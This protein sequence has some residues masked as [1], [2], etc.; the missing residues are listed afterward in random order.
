MLSLG[1]SS[2][3]KCGLYKSVT[4]LRTDPKGAMPVF[5]S[6]FFSFRGVHGHFNGQR[7]WALADECI[8]DLMADLVGRCENLSLEMKKNFL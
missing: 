4:F 6:C 8:V 7:P 5:I 1:E 3:S 2:S